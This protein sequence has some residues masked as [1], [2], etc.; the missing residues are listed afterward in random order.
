MTRVG[1]LALQGAFAK[2]ITMLE[3]IGV[4]GVEV[5]VAA[6]LE[7]CVALIIPGGES[8]AITKMLQRSELVTPLEEL[9]RAGFPVF[10]TCAGMIVLS[11]ALAAASDVLDTAMDGAPEANLV[12][13]K[14]DVVT[15]AA[16]DI[17]VERN[18][19]GRQIDS[20]E[21][22]VEIDDLD[23][24]SFR[25]VFIRAPKVVRVGE[26]VEVLAEVDG[27]PV[28]CRSGSVL[29]SSFHPELTDDARVHQLF[30]SMARSGAL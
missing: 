24:P 26:S 1:V 17:D 15:F 12:A 29:V 30:L 20:F 9:L 14:V 22:D 7:G 21:T 23:G 16:I 28:L 6:D 19:Y 5:R 18:A 25:A 13:A 11:N 4:Y 8:T 27:N 3:S 10:G 2:H